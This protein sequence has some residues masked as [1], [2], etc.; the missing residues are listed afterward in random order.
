MRIIDTIGNTPIVKLKTGIYAKL[1][2]FNPTGSIKD[3]TAFGMLD[4]AIKKGLITEKGIV[5][6][7]S[8]NT[9]IS[10]AFLGAYLD[11]PI[12]IIMPENFSRQRISI[13][14]SF[15]ATVVLTDAEE[16]MKGS[17][18]KAEELK[19]EGYLLL[20]QFSNP[21]NPMI[22]ELT[23]AVEIEK[24]LKVDILVCGVGTGGTLTGIARKLKKTNPNLTVVATEPAGSPFL[25]EGRSGQHKIQGIGA[26][27]LPKVLD[28]KLID[29][30]E[31]ITDE[32][33]FLFN[34][35]LLKEEGI[36]AGISSGAAY[37]AA[38]KLKDEYPKKTILAI[39]PDSMDRY[40]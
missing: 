30:V 15:G 33:A 9:G 24:E 17:I 12:T 1:E 7:T 26:G 28:I 18:K 40:I 25:S 39:F 4:D 10:L 34:D 37:C 5:E 36:F 11:I 27:F 20:D 19:K 38:L 14:E 6:P 23:T 2:Y 29:R 13:M 35:K 8:G 3:R 16:G 21:A 32:E 31:K 22:H